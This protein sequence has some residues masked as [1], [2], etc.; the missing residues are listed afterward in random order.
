VAL[1]F[2]LIALVLYLALVTQVCLSR[3]AARLPAMPALEDAV[4]SIGLCFHAVA[5]FAPL[6]VASPL[7]LGAAETLSMT[8]WLSLLIYLLLHLKMRIEGLQTL[9]LTFAITFLGCALLLPASHPLIYPLGGLARLHFGLAMLSYGLFAN[10]AALALLMLRADRALHRRNVLLRALPP[11]LTLEKLLFL[12]VTGGLVLLTSVLVTGA[13]FSEGRAFIWP[14]NQKALFSVASWLVFA[15]L[16]AGH[17]LAGWRGRR[18]AN[19]TLAGFA[20]LLLGYLGA[21]LL[22][23]F[24]A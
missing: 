2:G 20:L 22:S 18:A 13:V 6:L 21:R 24:L 10:A 7:R 9:I 11:L 15:L 23:D 8:A 5:L 14:L 3:H 19:W 12:C 17:Y 4:L 16:L 1:W